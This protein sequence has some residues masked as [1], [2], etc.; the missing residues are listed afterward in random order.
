MPIIL[1]ML[2]LLAA[3]ALSAK[4]LINIIPWALQKA[5][6]EEEKRRDDQ[7]GGYVQY[8]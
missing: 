4:Y 8:N 3:L 1:F 7:G 6:R 5:S 2:S